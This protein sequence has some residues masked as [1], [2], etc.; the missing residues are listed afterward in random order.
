M[1]GRRR[2]QGPISGAKLWPRDLA[3]QHLELVAQDH[4]LEVLGVQAT[5]TPNEC[6]QQ[7]PEGDVEEGEG[8]YRRSSQPTREGPTRVLAP[9][10]GL[11]PPDPIITT[12]YEC[13]WWSSEGQFADED[14]GVPVLDFCSCAAPLRGT[15]PTTPVSPGRRTHASRAA[16]A[17]L[18]RSRRASSAALRP[19]QGEG[20]AGSRGGSR[21]G[22]SRP[23]GRRG[24]RRGQRAARASARSPGD[25]GSRACP[26]SGSTRWHGA[27]GARR[28]GAG[29]TAKRGRGPRCAR[30]DGGELSAL[31]FGG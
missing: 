14:G 23:L 13:P 19:W 28:A 15:T 12:L 3:A 24:A 22:A 11:E 1:A 10:R 20:R 27:P 9:F 26:S 17:V 18:P 4:Q 31:A 30:R 16:R 2:E 8:H 5:A 7:G 21:G 29:R 25:F 6:A